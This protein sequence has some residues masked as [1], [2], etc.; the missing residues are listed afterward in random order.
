MEKV[1]QEGK[2]KKKRKKVENERN[3]PG[4]TSK[5]ERRPLTQLTSRSKDKMDEKTMGFEFPKEM[6]EGEVLEDI[7]IELVDDVSEGEKENAGN[8]MKDDD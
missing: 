6:M 2:E 7:E 3:A 1:S 8:E 4:K 5:L